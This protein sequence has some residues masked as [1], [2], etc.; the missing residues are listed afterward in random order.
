[1][2]KFPNLLRT[3]RSLTFPKA[4]KLMARKGS[5]VALHHKGLEPKYV[6]RQGGQISL[7]YYT[8]TKDKPMVQL[9]TKVEPKGKYHPMLETKK[10]ALYHQG[11]S[12]LCHGRNVRRWLWATKA[13]YDCTTEGMLKSGFGLPRQIMFVPRMVCK[14]MVLQYQGKSCFGCKP[15]V[16]KLAWCTKTNHVAATN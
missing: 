4:F 14:I 15:N 10:V 5:R 9:P 12:C 13:N 6:P 1:L 2:F 11:K 3:P 8:N 7:G 16:R